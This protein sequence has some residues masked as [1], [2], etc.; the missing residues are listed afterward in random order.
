MQSWSSFLRRIGFALLIPLFILTLGGQGFSKKAPPD[1][2]EIKVTIFLLPEIEACKLAGATSF[3]SESA[4][5]TSLNLTDLR[6]W[7]KKG[8]LSQSA[9]IPP[10]GVPLSSA[11]VH[12]LDAYRLAP[13]ETPKQ[14]YVAIFGFEFESGTPQHSELF[15][16]R[17][18]DPSYADIPNKEWPGLSTTNKSWIYLERADALFPGYKI[19]WVL[20]MGKQSWNFYFVRK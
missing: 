6:G 15:L 10:S 5:C 17:V 18:V 1:L 9:I 20:T 19:K 3:E 14:R 4:V 7:K 12:F 2:P 13:K 16:K 8:I 11:I